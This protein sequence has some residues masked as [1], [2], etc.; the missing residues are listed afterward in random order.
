MYDA[1]LITCNC[2]LYCEGSNYTSL[3]SIYFSHHHFHTFT[4][5]V[6]IIGDPQNPRHSRFLQ[7]LPPILGGDPRLVDSPY[8]PSHTPVS[9]TIL[10][11]TFLGSTLIGSNSQGHTSISSPSQGGR[12]KTSSQG[13]STTPPNP[14]QGSGPLGP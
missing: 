13:R 6:D 5:L 10:E 4:L 9:S 11:S 7:N 1:H 2:E 3:L 8:Q 12:G 14:P